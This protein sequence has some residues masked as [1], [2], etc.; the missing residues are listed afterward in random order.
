MAKPTDSRK[1]KEN[2][3]EPTP[4][5]L[6]GRTKE[7]FDMRNQPWDEHDDE[8]IWIGVDPNAPF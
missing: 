1:Q 6:L 4:W 3:K 7:E 2:K 8:V 5:E